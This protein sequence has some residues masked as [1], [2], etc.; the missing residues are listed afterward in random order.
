LIDYLNSG[1]NLYI[2]G[3]DLGFYNANGQGYYFGLWD[4]LGTQYLGDGNDYIVG[5]V[6]SLIGETDT[7]A[8]GYTFGYP[9]QGY[10]GPDNYVDIFGSQGGGAFQLFHSQDGLGRVIAL[11]ASNYRV[12][13]SS[14]I[15]G[16]TSQQGK[17]SA[18]ERTELMA[19]YL[20]FFA[21]GS[22]IQPTSLG[23]I[24]ALWH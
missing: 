7:P 23:V 14:V 20:E 19:D 17:D 6:S 11:I 18:S 22:N 4:Y 16:F 9:Y 12:V 13:T 8:A 1:G 2:E 15:F 5:N 24:K 21:G 3:C 10:E